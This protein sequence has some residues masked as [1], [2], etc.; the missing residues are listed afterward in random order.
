[1][2]VDINSPQLEVMSVTPE[3]STNEMTA[4]YKAWDSYVTD[5]LEKLISYRKNNGTDQWLFDIANV[6]EV[7][8]LIT[9]L[10][11][12]TTHIPYKGQIMDMTK[13][14]H[15]WFAVCPSN[16]ALSNLFR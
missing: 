15:I 14:V 13:Y 7:K 3:P 11:E 12:M 6:S 4:L 9:D 16:Y 5:T 8:A 1:M 2:L 10:Q